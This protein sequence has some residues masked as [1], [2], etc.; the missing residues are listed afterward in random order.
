[1]QAEPLLTSVKE[2]SEQNNLEQCNERT[3]A[4]QMLCQFPHII[5]RAITCIKGVSITPSPP[6]KKKK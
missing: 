2:F 6:R 3:D 5:L 1:M 4:H